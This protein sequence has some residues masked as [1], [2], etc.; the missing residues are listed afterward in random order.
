MTDLL[1]FVDGY[2]MMESGVTFMRVVRLGMSAHPATATATSALSFARPCWSAK[3]GALCWHGSGANVT[4]AAT[5]SEPT[6]QMCIASHQ[7]FGCHLR[8]RTY[9]WSGTSKLL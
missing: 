8:M 7:L 1:R 2:P 9:S 3:A 4:P 5:A 6:P